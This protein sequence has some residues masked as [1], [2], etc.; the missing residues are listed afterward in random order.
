MTSIIQITAVTIYATRFNIQQFYFLPPDYIY[1]DL[2][3]NSDYFCIR[4]WL[5]DFISKREGLQRGTNTFKY[6]SG[7]TWFF[8]WP[9]HDSG[10]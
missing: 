5:I 6:I 9:Y 2:R 8:K 10:R 1:L 7:K 3:E 4:H